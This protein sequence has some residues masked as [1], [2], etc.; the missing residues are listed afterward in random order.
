MKVPALLI[1]LL[2]A[3]GASLAAAGYQ[4][5]EVRDGGSIR[6][7]VRLAGPAPAPVAFAVAKDVATCGKSRPSQRLALGPGGGV[8]DAVVY[9]EAVA[10]G[11]R[12]PRDLKVTV[13]QRGCEYVP[14]V[15]AL[16]VGAQLELVNNDPVLH[17]VRACP[18]GDP[19]RVLFNIAQP[20]PGQ[21]TAIEQTRLTKPGIVDLSCDAG[22]RWMSAYVVVTDHPYSAVTGADGS[23]V[24]AGVPA[25]RYRLRMWHA[26]VAVARDLP[27]FDRVEYEPAYEAV[28]DVEVAAGREARADFTLTLRAPAQAPAKAAR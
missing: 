3:A 19:S 13:D 20:L 10:R 26:G 22:H 11:K 28:R 18:H 17:N 5:I 6:G 9:L 2:V 23:Y 12:L 7:V 16:P 1:A 21:R 27:S 8:R 24:L 14:H 15:L 4:E 25:G